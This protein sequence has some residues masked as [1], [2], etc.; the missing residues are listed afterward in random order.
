[1]ALYKGGGSAERG[2]AVA[3]LTFAVAHT[4]S[5]TPLNKGAIVAAEQ[6]L[7]SKKPVF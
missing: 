3:M 4:F 2:L 5:Y 1:M 7:P 6:Q